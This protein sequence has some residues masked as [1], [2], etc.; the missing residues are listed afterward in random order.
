MAGLVEWCQ[1]RPHIG[2][3]HGGVDGDNK[4]SIR[5]LEKNGF[6]RSPSRENHADELVLTLSLRP[7]IERA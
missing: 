4:A 6:V 5:V 2:S 1:A 3:L 7:R